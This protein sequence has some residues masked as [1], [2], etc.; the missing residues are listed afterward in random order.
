ME[1]IANR[2]EYLEDQL[3]GASPVIALEYTDGILFYTDCRDRRKLF[4]VYDRIG[5]GAIG[6]PGDIERLRMTAIDIAS[7][8]GFTRSP[9]DVSLRRLAYFGLSPVLKGAFE[10]VYGPPLVAKLLFV[11]LGETSAEDLFLI[12]DFDGGAH[13][14]NPEHHFAVIAGQSGYAEKIE[15]ALRSSWPMGGELPTLTEA[16]RLAA[17]ALGT[18]NSDKPQGEGGECAVLERGSGTRIRW[19]ALTAETVREALA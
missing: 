8:E 16:L 11:E 13:G 18:Q 12:L 7:A 1:A 3:R 10:Q 6:H 9:A 5:L 14:R 15:G 17:R 19:R 4:E 2:R